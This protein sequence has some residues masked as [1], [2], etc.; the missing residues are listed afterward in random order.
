MGGKWES[1][2][3]SIRET[4]MLKRE[5][6]YDHLV[7][8]AQI[9]K[10]GAA[11]ED[12]ES[13]Q[14]AGAEVFAA[15]IQLGVFRGL[16]KEGILDLESPDVT[17]GPTNDERA[18]DLGDKVTWL[19]NAVEAIDVAVEECEARNVRPNGHMPRELKS[20]QEVLHR[21]LRELGHI[22]GDEDA[23]ES[24]PPS[25]ATPDTGQFENTAPHHWWDMPPTP[26][27]YQRY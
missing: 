10:R 6:L 19:R 18:R 15:I 12:F 7:D 13:V 9:L 8:L 3:V 20:V 2:A 14:D 17:T 25:R 16:E 26:P 4:I 27:G 21:K 11:I 1:G 22:V 24:Y 5:G 23:Q